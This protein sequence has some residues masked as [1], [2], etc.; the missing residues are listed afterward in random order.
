MYAY[1]FFNAIVAEISAGHCT[2]RVD[3]GHV[4]ERLAHC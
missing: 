1:I 3:T 2:Q 4:F